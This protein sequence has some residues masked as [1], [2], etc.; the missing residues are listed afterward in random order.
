MDKEKI[1]H[2][3]FFIDSGIPPFISGLVSKDSFLG[4]YLVLNTV[5]LTSI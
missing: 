2:G 5:K 4:A 1:N 3:Y